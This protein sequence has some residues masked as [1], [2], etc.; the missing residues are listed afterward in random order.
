MQR[1]A[2]RIRAILVCLI[3]QTN[4]ANQRWRAIKYAELTLFDAQY[5]PYVLAVSTMAR[6]FSSGVSRPH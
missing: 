1:A 5:R 6:R 3:F 4:G 2:I